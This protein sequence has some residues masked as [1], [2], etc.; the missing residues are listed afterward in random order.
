MQNFS[1]LRL[2]GRSGRP[3]LLKRGMSATITEF[4]MS[5]EYILAE[6]NRQVILCERG[7]RG[8][9]SQQTRN[10]L[11]L[12]AIPVV[13]GLSHLPIIADPS[14]GT[15]VRAKV[16]PM[17]RAAVAAGADGLMVEVHPDPERALSDG[18]QSLYP[19]QFGEMMDQIALIAE[20][21]GR[22]LSPSLAPAGVR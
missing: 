1:L 2:A 4:L 6:G 10:L 15:G 19:D 9:D 11:D 20:A 12:T 21:I 16:I 5:A 8:F 3:V 22:T 14:H 18:A 17:A 7:V 13:K